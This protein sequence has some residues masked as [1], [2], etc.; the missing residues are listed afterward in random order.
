MR[1]FIFVFLIYFT[2]ISCCFGQD[3]EIKG[4][5]TIGWKHYKQFERSLKIYKFLGKLDYEKSSESSTLC[6]QYSVTF[7]SE[8]D[9]D[10]FDVNV[11]LRNARNY[12]SKKRRE[13]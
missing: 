4:V 5:Y 2:A 3:A 7:S 12:L 11:G 13:K 10:L 1:K 6:R 8:E 9:M